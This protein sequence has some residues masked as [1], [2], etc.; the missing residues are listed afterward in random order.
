MKIF[1]GTPHTIRIFRE[2]DTFGQGRKLFLEEGAQPLVEIPSHGTLNAQTENGEV[3]S[4]FQ[5]SDIPLVGAVQFTSVDPLPGLYDLYVVS[6]MY[7]SA[8]KELGYST[9][10]LATISQA[11]YDDPDNPRPVGCRALAVG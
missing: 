6:N 11:V 9:E 1:N 5:G 2:E 4:A 10:N 7:R 3:P 8:M